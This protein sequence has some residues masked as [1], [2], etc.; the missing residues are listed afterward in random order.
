MNSPTGK[1]LEISSI[2]SHINSNLL[3]SREVSIIF[4]LLEQSINPKHNSMVIGKKMTIK[5]YRK[6]S[7][8]YKGKNQPV[9]KIK[10]K[11]QKIL[12]NE[13]LNLIL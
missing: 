12:S 7:I 8:N 9:N 3:D 11:L 10:Q 1:K 2:N 4:A 5:L 13:V 6:K